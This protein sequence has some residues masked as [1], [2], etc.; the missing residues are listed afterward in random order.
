MTK[1]DEWADDD[2]KDENS[3]FE[4]I[5]KKGRKKI[6]KDLSFALALN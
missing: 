2:M 6:V 3:A 5:S 4:G 1:K